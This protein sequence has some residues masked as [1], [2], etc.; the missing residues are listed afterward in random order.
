MTTVTIPI[1]APTTRADGTALTQAEIARMDVEFSVDNGVTFTNVGHAA[2]NQTSFV[3]TDLS[4]GSYLARA[5]ATD[6]QT[7][8][9]TSIPSTVVSFVIPVPAL[10][11]PNPPVLGTPVVS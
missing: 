9:L 10:A 3:A 2:A 6:T 8:P 1:T 5:T 4:P 7:P 11:A